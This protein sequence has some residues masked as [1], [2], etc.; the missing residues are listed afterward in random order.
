M[1]LIS[2]RGNIFGRIDSFENK[3]DY[4]DIAISQCFDVEVDI[5]FIENKLWLGHD[6]PIHLINIDWL[7]KNS[8][9]LWIHCK[10][11]DALYYLKKIDLDFNY[12]WH[13][14]DD[15]TI[16]SKGYFWTFPGK[17]LTENS[18]ACMPEVSSFSNIDL[19]YGICSDFV[20][21]YKN[22][23]ANK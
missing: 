5:W 16:T 22:E 13:Q 19:G 23:Y 7:R 1:K 14:N 10:N 6:E 21:L 17:Q 3:P 15:V 18:I 8:N 20:G 9:M 2:H 11:I 4:I 12:F